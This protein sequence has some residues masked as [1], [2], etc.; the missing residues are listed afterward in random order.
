MADTDVLKMKVADLKRELKLRGLS[1]AGNKNELQDRL[2]TVLIDGELSLE[3]TAI[4]EDLLD[5]DVLTDEDVESAVLESPIEESILSP[6]SEID[7]KLI[8]PTKPGKKVILKRK[9]SL[10]IPSPMPIAQT[11]IN[12]IVP[13][14]EKITKIEYN[15]NSNKIT[16]SINQSNGNSENLVVG[17]EKKPMKVSQLTMKERL[18]MRAK[19]FGIKEGPTVA[20]IDLATTPSAKIDQVQD[21]KVI[22]ALK[23]RAERFGCV[24]SPQIVE[25]E[26]AEKLQKRAERFGTNNTIKTSADNSIYAEKAKLRLERFKTAAK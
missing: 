22:E 23:K 26:K 24:V 9:A 19:K 1:I 10:T 11:T 5:E 7:L 6:R 3:D 18:E 14:A 2:Q 21:V 12:D 8:E 20:S 25:I 16:T 17:G 15:E 4:S 13:P